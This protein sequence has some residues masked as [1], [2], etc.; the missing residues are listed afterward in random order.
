MNEQMDR[1]SAERIALTDHI[2]SMEQNQN[3]QAE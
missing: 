2:V 3:D 1:E